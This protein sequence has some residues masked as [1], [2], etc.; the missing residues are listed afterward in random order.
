MP[1]AGEAHRPGDRNAAHVRHG[2][3]GEFCRW[4]WSRASALSRPAPAH[5][6]HRVEMTHTAATPVGMTVTAEVELVNR[7]PHFALQGTLAATK[8]GRWARDL[9]DARDRQ[10]PFL[11]GSRGGSRYDSSPISSGWCAGRGR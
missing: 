6:R 3:D 4:N 2:A 10:R 8:K 11:A 9:T 5:G 7:R 1:S